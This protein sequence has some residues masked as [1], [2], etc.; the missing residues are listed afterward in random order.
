MAEKPETAEVR[1]G[2]MAILLEGL[3]ESTTLGEIQDI[4]K[5]KTTPPGDGKKLK[6]EKVE[7]PEGNEESEEEE[8][9]EEQEESEEGK[10]KKPA[11]GKEK[12]AKNKKTDTEDEEEEE[13]SEEEE[14]E[15]ETPELNNK[16]GIKLG[17]KDDKKAASKLEIKSFDELPKVLKSK[18]GQEI[19]DPKALSKFLD[20]TVDKWRTDSQNLDKVTKEKDNAIAVFEQLP[21]ELLDAVKLHYEGQDFRKA[22]ESNV[23]LDFSKTVDKQKPKSLVNAFFPGEF[24]DEDFDAD[25][26]SKELKIAIKASE[27]QYNT[28]KTAREQRAKDQV[29]RAGRKDK[30]YKESI[31]SS[32]TALKSAF[33]DMPADVQADVEHTLSSGALMNVFLN[34]DGTYKPHAAKALMLANHGEELIE[35]LMQIAELR[36]ESNANEEIV[37]RSPGKPKGTKG[38]KPAP[39]RKEVTAAVN[40]LLPPGLVTKR[41]F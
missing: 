15:D 22:F 39:E 21:P 33:P 37:K 2:N 17:K 4:E 32:V 1:G 13:E 8:Q 40:E 30:A 34:P 10:G 9:E 23:K 26:P 7:K 12:P 25:E 20:G 38:Q 31:K 5:G 6:N 36:G 41:T 29:E 14:E 27:S 16:F 35:Q 28:E 19:K 24:T 3:V 11:A 18:Y